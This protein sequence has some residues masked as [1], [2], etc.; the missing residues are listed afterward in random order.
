MLWFF[1]QCVSTRACWF[2]FSLSGHC[3][4]NYTRGRWSCTPEIAVLGR[5]RGASACRSL[6][7]AWPTCKGPSLN[8]WMNEW[9]NNRHHDTWR[10]NQCLVTCL[11]GIIDLS[12]WL[13]WGWGERI[14]RAGTPPR[15]QSD[16]WSSLG[17]F[18]GL[19]YS[20]KLVTVLLLVTGAQGRE[21]GTSP[22]CKP[23]SATWW[24]PDYIA[25]QQQ[26][27]AG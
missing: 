25:R 19:S 4:I 11:P 27:G 13:S 18:K 20:E 7:P 23:P 24:I 9:M 17:N 10:E 15:L 21:S 1:S 26:S 5:L 12:S 6:R 14:G 8:G 3:S 22:G 16:F 2:D